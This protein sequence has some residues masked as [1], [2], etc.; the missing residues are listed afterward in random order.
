MTNQP[1]LHSRILTQAHDAWFSAMLASTRAASC[2]NSLI[3]C[4]TSVNHSSPSEGRSNV[5]L[6]LGPLGSRPSQSWTRIL[7]WPSC[8]AGSSVGERQWQAIQQ[9]EDG[10]LRPPRSVRALRNEPGAW[11]SR[12][13]YRRLVGHLRACRVQAWR[14]AD[15]GG[16]WVYVAGLSGGGGVGDAGRDEIG[17][18]GHEGFVWS[19]VSL[20]CRAVWCVVCCWDITCFDYF[21]IATS[22]VGPRVIF[23]KDTD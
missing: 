4:Y 1:S 23:C 17:I 14:M 7:R 12:A 22:I 3:T 6:P 18:G 20:A 13:E 15:A 2:L 21:S 10:D 11:K 19:L 9:R 5:C 8:Q 16:G